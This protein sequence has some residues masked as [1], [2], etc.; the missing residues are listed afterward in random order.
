ML[1]EG[2]ASEVFD[3]GDGTVLR[4]SKQGSDYRREAAVMRHALAAGLP[5]PRVR[6]VEGPEIVLDRIDGPTMLDDLVRH[7]WRLGAHARLLAA[8]HARVHAVAAPAAA[9]TAPMPGDRLLHLDLHPANVLLSPT[10]PVLIDW[11]NAAAGDPA[12]DL[13]VTWVLM[14]GADA[15]GSRVE[16]AAIAA[17]RRA[18]LAVWLRRV[19]R[20]DAAR[21]LAAAAEMRAADR[22]A[23]PAEGDRARAL[24]ARHGAP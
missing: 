3:L 4:R 16:L 18:F 22:N 6:S 15:A 21:G 19:G 23:T 5:V 8:L 9:A 17:F 10:G 11:E 1:A 2:R 13:A 12:F 14:D 20:A 24:A 7:P